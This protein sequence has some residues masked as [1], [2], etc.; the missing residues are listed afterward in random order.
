MDD[1]VVSS[2]IFRAMPKLYAK[3]PVGSAFSNTIAALG[4]ACLSNANRTLELMT[5]A[6]PK[7]AAAL[8]S[9]D[10]AITDPVKAQSDNQL[11]IVILMAL[12]EEVGSSS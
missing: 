8:R 3:A 12:Y 2:S 7:Y 11:M 4:M 1:S 9:I 10:S 6:A 5:I